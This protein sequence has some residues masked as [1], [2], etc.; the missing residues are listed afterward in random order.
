VTLVVDV[1]VLVNAARRDAADH[2]VARAWLAAALVGDEPVALPDPVVTGCLRILSEP[3]IFRDAH[4]VSDAWQWLAVILAAPAVVTVRPGSRHWQLLGQLCDAL[5]LRG[6]DVPDAWLA[7]LCL[8]HGG[9]LVSFD[10]GFGRFPR[11]SWHT[12]ADD[13]G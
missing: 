13:A 4:A 12:P 5:D 8:E 3:R 6:R 9:S 11:L 1:N 2:E 7:A 10:R